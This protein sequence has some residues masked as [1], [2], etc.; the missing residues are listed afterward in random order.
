MSFLSKRNVFTVA[1]GA[2]AL[3]LIFKVSNITNVANNVIVNFVKIKLL[4]TFLNPEVILTLSATNPTT[5]SIKIN[6]I[7]GEIFLPGKKIA[8][9]FT[10]QIFEVGASSVVNFD[11]NVIA[12][13]GN[14]LTLLNSPERKQLFFKGFITIDGFQLPIKFNLF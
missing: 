13:I 2:A 7:V 11:V 4:G 14:I 10:N 3:W 12:T 1:A 5:S 9:V 8:D 6:A